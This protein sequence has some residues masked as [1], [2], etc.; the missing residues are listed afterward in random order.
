[1]WGILKP[2]CGLWTCC[3]R[4]QGHQT[5]VKACQPTCLPTNPPTSWGILFIFAG[6]DELSVEGRKGSRVVTC[7]AVEEQRK[8][9]GFGWKGS[10]GEGEW[11]GCSNEK[12]Q[13]MWVTVWWNALCYGHA[14]LSR[15]EGV[16]VWV[17]W[18]IMCTCFYVFGFYRDDTWYRLNSFVNCTKYR[19]MTRT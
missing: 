14:V 19:H 17:H 11:G 18:R 10:I 1:M 8:K 3:L 5:D 6:V 15:L 12:G 7:K 9:G 4:L 16:C 2:H 13:Q